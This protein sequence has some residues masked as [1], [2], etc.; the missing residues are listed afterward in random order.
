MCANGCWR[1]VRIFTPS[2]IMAVLRCIGSCADWVHSIHSSRAGVHS[3]VPHTFVNCSLDTLITSP[4][5]LTRPAA[6]PFSDSVIP[7]T[8]DKTLS[9]EGTHIMSLFT[10]WVPEDWSKEP[11]E[12]EIEA[13][14]D[15]M[16]DAYNEVAP[17]FKSSI[18]HR[19]VVSSYLELM[20][21]GRLSRVRSL[22]ALGGTCGHAGT[23][24]A[25]YSSATGRRPLK[26]W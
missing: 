8:F 1:P 11:H 17:N 21:T 7:T 6:R 20:M 13:Y 25:G 14:A 2:T 18:I 19:D 26:N 15:R 12:A 23:S 4:M 5:L 16:V 22:V 9:P 10:Q 3:L 24:P